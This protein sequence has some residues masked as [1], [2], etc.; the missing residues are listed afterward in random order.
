[1][2]EAS[3]YYRPDD[4]GRIS[5]LI[6]R[7]G[8]IEAAG[9]RERGRIRSEAAEKLGGYL[10]Q[11][12]GGFISSAQESKRENQRHAMAMG[13]FDTWKGDPDTLIKGMAKIYGVERGTKVANGILASKQIGIENDLKEH[14]VFRL[15]VGALAALD[16]STLKAR[17]NELC[18]FVVGRAVRWGWIRAQDVPKEYNPFCREAII[19]IDRKINPPKARG[20]AQLRDVTDSSGMTT[21]HQYDPESNAWSPAPGLPP[22]T[23]APPKPAASPVIGSPADELTQRYGP[24]PTAAQIDQYER[25]VAARGRQPAAPRG[26]VMEVPGPNGTIIRRRVTEAELARGVTV[27]PK[28]TGQKPVTGAERQVLAFFNRAKKASEDVE[29]IEGKVSQYGVLD[30]QRLAYEGV[31]GNYAKSQEMQAYRQAQRTFT[32]ARLRKESGAAIPPE[33]YAN[34]AKTYFAQ[35]G[36][37]PE[38]IE[39]KRSG[40]EV[41]LQGLAYSSG[42][43]YEEFYGEPAPRANAPKTAPATVGPTGGGPKV[44]DRKTFPNGR[45]GE[46]DGTGWKLV[47]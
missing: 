2:G 1:M 33:E 36:D 10:G 26:E 12:I 25:M 47:Q 37:T 8:E 24:R 31:G 35:P 41:V 5:S 30:Q 3:P 14:E 16:E 19:S 15:Q 32:E 40:R 21:T 4:S 13:F 17:W 29:P 42:R 22:S 39:Q 11:T 20:A 6:M 23:A 44:G 27:P 9:I 45:T 38:T 7:Q 43:A 34:D 28:S 18:P 46:W